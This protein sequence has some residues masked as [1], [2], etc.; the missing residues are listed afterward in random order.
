MRREL[1]VTANRYRVSF[2]GDGNFLE[3]DGVMVA[4]YCEFTKNH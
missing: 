1:R 2:R 3:L 4:Q